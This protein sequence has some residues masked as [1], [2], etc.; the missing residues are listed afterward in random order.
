MELRE[1]I[2]QLFMVGFHGVE[3]ADPH[4]EVLRSVRPGG[5]ILFK[6][7]AQNPEQVARLCQEAQDIA[8]ERGGPPLFVAIDQEGGVVTRLEP[9]FTQFPSQG[10]LVDAHYEEV[11]L[12]GEL[13]AREMKLVGLN[14]NLAPV[15]DVRRPDDETKNFHRSFSEDPHRVATLGTALIRGLQTNG[16]MACAKHFPGLGQAKVDPHVDLPV[17]DSDLT[18]ELIP[19]L[20]AIAQD[21]SAVMMSHAIYPTLDPHSQASLS[22]AAIDGLLRKKLGY[23]GLVITDDLEMGAITRS[24]TLDECSVTAFRGGAD[25]LLICSKLEAIPECFEGVMG[26]IERNAD[27]GARARESAARIARAKKQY[28]E[29]YMRPDFAEIER[30]FS[31][32]DDQTR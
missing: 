6:R 11:F 28:L 29:P 4:R 3:L 18:I 26:E 15:L 10:D 9:P 27:L 5:I 31:E 24:Y 30:Y 7:N 23:G 19:F 21:V 1:S 14:M 20:G 16:V 22:P 32:K 12:R 13:M 25:I 17:V 2:G 8:T